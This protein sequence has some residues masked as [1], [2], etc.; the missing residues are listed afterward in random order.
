MQYINKEDKIKAEMKWLYD[1]L[2]KIF[3]TND[4]LEQA[5]KIWEKF[6]S[7][8]EEKQKL[9]VKIGKRNIMKMLTQILNA[10]I[11]NKNKST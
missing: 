3:K 1:K 5:L 10:K 2:T 7:F 6:M 4:K 11:A 8:S 9:C